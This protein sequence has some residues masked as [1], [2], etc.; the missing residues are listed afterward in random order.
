MKRKIDYKKIL[1]LLLII[2]NIF[3]TFK[4]FQPTQKDNINI[5]QNDNIKSAILDYSVAELPE[6]DITSEE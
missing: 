5:T 4:I 2:W 6:I 1:I 3:L